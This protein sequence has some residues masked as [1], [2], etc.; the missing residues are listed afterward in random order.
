LFLDK[1][2]LSC[3]KSIGKKSH[4]IFFIGIANN[5]YLAYLRKNLRSDKNRSTISYST[6]TVHT[7]SYEI[8]NT[9]TK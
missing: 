8:K 7:S 4:R 9:F 6:K 1:I 2:A 5:E 3:N